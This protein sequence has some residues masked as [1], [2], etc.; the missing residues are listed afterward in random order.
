MISEGRI[1]AILQ[2]LAQIRSDLPSRR[3]RGEHGL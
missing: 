3:A 2:R 1:V